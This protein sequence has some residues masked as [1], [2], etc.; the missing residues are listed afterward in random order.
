MPATT[1]LNL[2]RRRG[3]T[4]PDTF[5]CYQDKNNGVFLDITNGYTF[6]MTVA[7]TP[8]PEDAAGV[9]FTV[10][11]VIDTGIDGEVKF[12]PT[13]GNVAS[14]G[15]YYYDIQLTG[16]DGSVWTLYTGRYTIKQDINKS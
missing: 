9:V 10:T 2:V 13:A 11:G 4:W 3:D 8:F 5:V 12:T 1:K 7:T 15:S 6:V 16:P 14:P